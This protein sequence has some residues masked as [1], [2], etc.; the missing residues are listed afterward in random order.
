MVPVSFVFCLLDGLSDSL[1]KKIAR[2]SDQTDQTVSYNH[3]TIYKDMC[4]A[5]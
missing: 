1:S 3:S 2:A 4:T 5:T